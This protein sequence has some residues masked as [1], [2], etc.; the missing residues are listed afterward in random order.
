[1]FLGIGPKACRRTDELTKELQVLEHEIVPLLF[2]KN[3]MLLTD[4]D[5]EELR[6]VNKKMENVKKQK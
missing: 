3:N 1:M 2:K 5:D 4:K 6:K